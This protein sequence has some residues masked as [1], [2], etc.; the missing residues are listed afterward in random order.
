MLIG[1]SAEIMGQTPVTVGSQVTSESQLVSG[2]AYLVYYVGNDA[3]VSGYMKDTGAAYTGK[4]D[5][6]ATT[7]AVYYFTTGSTTG[8][9]K[10]QNYVTGKYWGTPTEEKNTYIG[11]ATG[12]DWAMNFQTGGN[13][14]PSCSNH[15]WNRSGSYVH[16]WSS[17]ADNVNQLRIYEVGLSVTA[18]DE[19]AGYDI[20][21]SSTAASDISAGQWY[22]M[23]DRGT[24]HGW[25]LENQDQGKLW[26]YKDQP[27]GSASDAC[28]YL[29]RLVSDGNGKYYIQTGY[30][31][32]FSTLVDGNRTG[33]TASNN[34]TTALK[35]HAYT[36]AKIA[37]TDGH[38]YLQ[39][40]ND[41]IM[42]ANDVTSYPTVGGS[43]VGL[44]TTVPLS[45]G[46]N[47][48][49]A[50]YPVELVSFTPT[51]NEVYTINNTNVGGT[52]GSLIYNPDASTKWVWATGKSGTFDASTANSQW[53]FVPTGTTDQY[54]L[55]NVGANKFAIPMK[56]G[57]FGN[58]NS[59]SWG[60][61][62][63]AVAIRLSA[64]DDGS[65]KMY[66]VANDVVISISTGYTGP[67]INFDDNGAKFNIAKVDGADASTAANTAL[68]KLMRN[69]SNAL[70][71]VPSGEGW[72]AMKIKSGTYVNE[73]V[74]APQGG[75]TYNGE[76]YPLTFHSEVNVQ[77]SISDT[78]YYT[79]LTKT[80]NGYSWQL[81][82]GRYLYNN[83]SNQFPTATMTAVDNV[84]LAYS[85]GFKFSHQNSLKTDYAVA[86][87]ASSTY[88]IGESDNVSN[89]TLF[90]LYPLTLS[91]ADLVA[92]K[93]VITNASPS[94][95]LSC[96][97]SDVSGLTAVYNDGY[98]FLPTGVTPT[99]SDFSM[100]GM[101]GTPVIDSEAKT[102]TA[103]YD[104]SISFLASDV[105]V[106][107]GNETTGKGN[108]MAAL[109]RVK[110][111]PFKACTPASVSLTLTGHEQLDKVA[112]YTTTIDEIHAAAASPV[113]IGEATVSGSS[114]T[115]T[116]SSATA[117]AAGTPTYLWVT[118]DV[119]STAT[120]WETI[121]AAI[122]GI[123][124][125]NDYTTEN[126]LEATSINLTSIGNPDGEMRIYKQQTALWTSQM[127]TP[128]YYR[129]PALLRTSATDILAF[130]DY[131][132]AST[133][134]LGKPATG[135]KIDVVMRKSSNGG[136]T[137]GDEIRVAP[138]DGSTDAGYGYG[139]PAVALAPNGDIVCLMA[140][141]RTSYPNGMLHI[142]FT[143]STDGGA[144]WSSPV[145]IYG[146]TTYLTNPHGTG[147]TSPF[148]STFVSSGHGITQSIARTGRIAFPALG[149]VSGTTN[150]YVI[151]SDDNGSTWTFTDSYGYTDAD[152]SK[153]LE[154]NDGNLLMS[155]RTG[156]Y[157]GSGAARGYNRT[158]GTY[159][160]NWDTQGTWSDLTGNGC[161]SDL[162]YYNRSTED[163]SRP[164]VIFHTMVKSY[165]GGRKD[166]R[167]Y[168]SFDEGA[169][170]KEAFQ[171]QPGFAAYSSMQKLANGDLAIIYEDGSIGNKDKGDC[172]AINYVVLSSELINAKIDELNDFHEQIATDFGPYFEESATGYF[173]LTS[174]AKTKLSSEYTTL[175]SSCSAA[176]Y[177]AFADK[178]KAGIQLPANGGYYRIRTAAMPSSYS[179]GT[180]GQY[181]YLSLD[182]S[183]LLS[184]VGSQK[185]SDYS[186]IFK[187]TKV[188]D[189]QYKL[190]SQGLY[191]QNYTA[192][193][194][195]LQ[196]TSSENTISVN[197][198]TP[199]I[200]NL[201]AGTGNHAN[202]HHSQNK[203]D[204]SKDA[205]KVV[206]WTY[207]GMA[208]Q[209]V[210][211]DA[212]NTII[213]VNLNTVGSASYATLY[214]PF[215]VTTDANTAAYYVS[216]ADN[217]YAQLTEVS[218]HEIAANTAVLLINET[219]NAATFEVTSGL[220]PQVSESA[221]LLKGTL[222]SRS[223]DLG[224]E[225]SY[226]SLGRKDGVIGF[227]KFD[228]GGTT[229]IT[230]GANKAYLDTSGSASPV[231]GFTFSFGDETS[232]DSL[233]P[234]LSPGG[235]GNVE[236][237]RT[238]N[239][240][241]QRVHKP[242]RG[243]YIIEGRKMIVK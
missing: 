165:S 185:Q 73:F 199:G 4:S 225:T 88:F 21:V 80:D 47:N 23:F 159:V 49:W 178:I 29:V 197:V 162:L 52:R 144:T 240:A 211:E 43:V 39:D 172:Y 193:N 228:N 34:G 151:Y 87:Y 158:T 231:K 81:T 127:T 79:H 166:L 6:V 133:E 126:S 114:V 71:A 10:V 226:Y 141:G 98:F 137:W 184:L 104:P 108:T 148:T 37:D 195:V 30:G 164:D 219:A 12:G 41:V 180:S 156:S 196:M 32:Y 171:L 101:V 8:T 120:E 96:T 19:L 216:S 109:L 149:K 201:R 229:T 72:Y 103:S 237:G 105:A 145:D 76:S 186:T 14:A 205:Y 94:T 33:V 214:L 208:S 160:E 179:R 66:S 154:L 170:W 181:Y 168:M 27:S 194:A 56:G 13:V 187:F 35:E 36:I 28:M 224:D 206:G 212:V 198:L 128:A 242:S 167:L 238:Y 157:N 117:L 138:G 82:D 61:S 124:Y 183:D 241:G 140:A 150:E 169:T 215:D 163:S 113:Q 11:S 89:G 125:S 107:Q 112:I 22:L 220:T 74:C 213:P 123:T 5:N 239:L 58:G 64:Q 2:K 189:Y 78:Y 50:F 218:N 15:S 20:S 75:A 102:I 38:F 173:A 209:W 233:S 177:N 59:Y 86:Y 192:D 146:N 207:D 188:G 90:D 153:L 70:S 119:K 68:G 99:A 31:N 121:D 100:A 222:V 131:R 135:H 25:F 3:S 139:D 97:R 26:N 122:T 136:L 118:A 232:I 223:L 85:S 7:E 115:V 129:I 42:D 155:I 16:P 176:Q 83:S 203:K 95:Q 9:W 60:F 77:P 190:Q 130:T 234:D 46:G 24:N 210:L 147:T 106:I 93:V 48:D 63:N 227:Y 1:G 18:L 51:I 57:T 175:C 69:L 202:L 62:D 92:W 200:I 243:I 67:V 45:I 132:Y 204:N 230:L 235:E 217:G 84:T 142:G 110:V 182:G 40:E 134:D 221:N 174:A 17:G 161:N 54:Y 53:V 152:E 44:G 236:A 111:T 55:Y 143:K 91:D 65:Y 191:L 116:T